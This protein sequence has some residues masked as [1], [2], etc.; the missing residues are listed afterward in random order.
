MSKGL[1][2]AGKA[3]PDTRMILVCAA[4]AVKR[5]K[6]QSRRQT[7]SKRGSKSRMAK[8]RSAFEQEAGEEMTE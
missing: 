7:G 4:V 8:A 6:E 2:K 3:G 1:K 5:E